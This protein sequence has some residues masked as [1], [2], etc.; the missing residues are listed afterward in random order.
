MSHRRVDPAAVSGCNGSPEW[1]ATSLVHQADDRV[2]ID[3]CGYGLAEFN[4]AEP[5]LPSGYIRRN[6][7]AK[8]IQVEKEEIV[9]ETRTGV[10]HRIAALLASQDREILRA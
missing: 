2:A 3:G 7:V 5:F 9:F 1:R 6:F 10:R 8:I 4:F